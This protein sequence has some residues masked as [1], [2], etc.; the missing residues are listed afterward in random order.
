MSSFLPVYTSAEIRKLEEAAAK[1]LPGLME[2]AGLAAAEFAR[3]LCGDTAKD[4]LVV[5]GPGNNGGDA[6]E[7]AAHLK[8]WFYR[9]S[10]V[11]A[12]KRE[13]LPAD[14]KAALA[15]WEA[16]GGTVLENI[17][18]ETRFDLV[19]DGLF[20]TGLARPLT[21]THAS[22]VNEM[23]ALGAPV[24]SL[25]VPSGIDADTGAVM[26][27]AV[28]A[29]HTVTFV[30]HKPGL[31][32]LDG[33]DHCGEIRLDALGLET[34]KLRAPEGWLLGRDV[35]ATAL[36]PRKKNFHKGQAGSVGILGGA[37]GM[38]GAAV[39]AGRAA[40]KCGAGRVYLGLLT[41]R[42]PYVDYAQ[43]ELMLRKPKEL[44]APELLDVLVAGPGMGQ[45][46][47]SAEM[48]RAA[49]KFP[50]ALLLDADALN[51][52]AGNR[53]LFAAIAA[54]KAATIMTPHPAEAARLLGEDT[55]KIQA[56]RIAA[57]LALARRCRSFVVLKGNGSVIAAPD[58]RWWIN[59]TG[60]PGM[61]SAGMGDALSGI[62]A[63]LVAQGAEP[64]DAL[65]SGVCLHGAAADEL[66]AAGTGPIGITASEVIERA[67]SLLN[68]SR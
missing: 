65:L 45:G 18:R 28:Q 24:L 42:P 54:R 67:R 17:P 47:A 68:R 4:L 2:R 3:E 35:F 36:A 63:A 30:A 48:L 46:K 25:D 31:W 29:N 58:G 5:A 59:P 6:F 1:T 19:V 38:I 43:P 12:G 10:V 55:K 41:P 57:A 14:A 15:K 22:L 7:V 44:F 61:A 13:R 21:G 33:P 11:F 34:A 66:V 60:N 32:T 20:G 62:V 51:L 50:A 52:C 37:A 53:A 23:N 8:R 27:C 16:A 39:I 56:D 40:L 9:V 26:G 64:L 49:L